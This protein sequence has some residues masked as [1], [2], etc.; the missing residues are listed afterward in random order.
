MKSCN[1]IKFACILAF[2][3]VPILVCNGAIDPKTAV[4]VWLFDE[5]VG[6]VAGD[7]SGNGHDGKIAVAT[8]ANGKFGKALL[9]A[10]DASVEVASTAKLNNGGQYTLMAYFNANTLND[11][12]QIIAKNNQYLLRIDPPGEGGKL[13]SFVNLNGGWEPRASAIVPDKDK[14]YH[15]AATYSS[16]TKKLTVFVDGAKAGESDREGNPTANN[17][18]VTFGHWGGGSRF[19]GLIDEVAI[20]NVALSEADI[21]TIATNG[22]ANALGLAGPSS[23]RS[24]EKIA[25]T[26]GN[27][28]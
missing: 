28:K 1:L 5:G 21:K 26:W 2:I 12:H 19:R 14:W 8:W 20:F 10:G 4:G 11:W 6:A 23:V 3:L 7:S 18:P 24:S 27:L 13:S 15:F 16:A 17:D 22:L 25:T 9:F